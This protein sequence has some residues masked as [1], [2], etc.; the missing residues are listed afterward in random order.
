MFT[1]TQ[2]IAVSVNKMRRHNSSVPRN[3]QWWVILDWRYDSYHMS[4]MIWLIWKPSKVDSSSK[5]PSADWTRMSANEHLELE[6]IAR[7]KND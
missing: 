2:Q 1:M 7:L 3:E 6:M 4:H 5:Y